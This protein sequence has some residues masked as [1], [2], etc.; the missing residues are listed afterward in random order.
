MAVTR[1]HEQRRGASGSVPPRQRGGIP[2]WDALRGDAPGG[3]ITGVEWPGQEQAVPATEKLDGA[4]SLAVYVPVKPIVTELDG[5][6]V[7]L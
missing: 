1:A 4:V 2:G 7:A 6:S 5:A 3:P